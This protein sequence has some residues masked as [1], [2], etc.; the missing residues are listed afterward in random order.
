[1][2]IV[3][4]ATGLEIMLSLATSQIADTKQQSHSGLLHLLGV[5]GILLVAH[6]LVVLLAGQL[7]EALQCVVP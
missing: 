2:T 5:Y 7:V 1:M 6:A 3:F 4:R